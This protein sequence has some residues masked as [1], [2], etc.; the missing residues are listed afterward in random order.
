MEKERLRQMQ[1]Q[2]GKIIPPYKVLKTEGNSQDSDSKL[3]AEI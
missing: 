1:M 3:A 2:S